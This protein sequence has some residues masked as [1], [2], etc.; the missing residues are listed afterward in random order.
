[1]ELE[2]YEAGIYQDSARHIDYCK[3]TSRILES[4]ITELDFYQSLREINWILEK[5]EVR[6]YQDS[7]KYRHNFQLTSGILEYE[8]DE[9]GFLPKSERDEFDSF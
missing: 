5:L 1:M 6:I 9:L 3:L 4:E 8:I 2:T 7:V